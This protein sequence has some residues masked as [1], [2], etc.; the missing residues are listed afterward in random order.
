MFSFELCNFR[1]FYKIVFVFDF[2]YADSYD[3]CRRRRSVNV[4]ENSQMKNANNCD[5]PVLFLF[6]TNLFSTFQFC[7]LILRLCSFTVGLI[8]ICANE[9]MS[10]TFFSL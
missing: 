4:G 10:T 6:F 8:M 1:I 3:D 2:R 5:N 9:M 7:F